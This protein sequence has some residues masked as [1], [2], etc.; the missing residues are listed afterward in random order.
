MT[1]DMLSHLSP[2][3]LEYPTHC[4]LCGTNDY[5][6]VYTIEPFTIVQCRFCSS[7]YL[8][9]RVKE[10]VIMK[11][12]DSSL[13][14]Q[15][16]GDYGYFDY[17]FQ[18]KG[19]R[20]SF[21]HLL[22]LLEREKL[23]GGKLLEIGCGPGFFLEE[24]KGL[25]VHRTGMEM[26]K[27]IVLPDATDKVIIGNLDTLTPADQFDLIVSIS[28]IEHVYNPVSFMK[29]L[30]GNLNRSGKVVIV[31]P[32]FNNI[33]RHIF[34]RRWP[35]F[36]IPEH[37]I[38]FNHKSL[39]ILARICGLKLISVFSV[40]QFFPLLLVLSKIFFSEN[41]FSFLPLKIKELLIPIPQTMTCGILG[42]E[43]P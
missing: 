7:G 16:D 2:E 34:R 15:S 9:P 24:A 27:N 5:H 26:C 20:K 13:Y 18:E 17:R 11:L 28:V 4:P 30:V 12:Y 1:S 21:R 8:S 37:V 43:I 6:H 10:D 3:E 14:Y 35:S 41:F 38:Y 36:K 39:D 23:T 33:W 19:L 32:D 42:R 29:S 31:T 25:F 40:T 22:R